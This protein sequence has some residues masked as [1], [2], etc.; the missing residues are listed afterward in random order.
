M[1]RIQSARKGELVPM[2]NQAPI[3]VELGHNPLA[4]GT[5]NASLVASANRRAS[6]LRSRYPRRELQ[7]AARKVLYFWGVLRDGWNVAASR[8]RVGMARDGRARAAGL[9]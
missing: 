4:N 7:L 2:S 3:V 6:V 5:F 8:G 9:D 1:V